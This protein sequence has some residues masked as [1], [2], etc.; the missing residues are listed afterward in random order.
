MFWVL[1]T[2]DDSI[3]LLSSIIRVN[4]VMTYD[5]LYCLRFENYKFF[6]PQIKEISRHKL[7]SFLENIMF[8]G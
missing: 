6:V 4:S 7:L 8:G 2:N 3:C 5:I 1:F